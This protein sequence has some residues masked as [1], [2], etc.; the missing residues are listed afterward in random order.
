MDKQNIFTKI[1]E[2]QDQR[3]KELLDLEMLIKSLIYYL[4]DILQN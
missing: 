1:F 2:N 3:T 4:L